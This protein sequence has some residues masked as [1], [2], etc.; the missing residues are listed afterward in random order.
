[1]DPSEQLAF[2]VVIA[3]VVVAGLWSFI[4]GPTGPF[5][6]SWRDQARE[7]E[8]RIRLG[9]GQAI[10]EDLRALAKLYVRLGRRWDGEQTLQRALRICEYELGENNPQTIAILEDYADLM[11]AMHRRGEAKAMKKRI[12]SIG[13]EKP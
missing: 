6:K 12:A 10:L 7:L 3:L 4:N 5:A 8:V 1:M 11:A 9:H 2:Y 13:K